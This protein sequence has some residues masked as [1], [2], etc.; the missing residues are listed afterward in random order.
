[1][2]EFDLAVVVMREDF[3]VLVTDAQ[4]FKCPLKEPWLFFLGD[5]HRCRDFSAV[6]LLGVFDGIRTILRAMPND[7]DRRIKIMPLGVLPVC[8]VPLCRFCD[9]VFLGVVNWRLLIPGGLCYLVHCE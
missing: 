2:T 9:A 7:L 5:A 4:L 8:P 6:I 1:M 3:D